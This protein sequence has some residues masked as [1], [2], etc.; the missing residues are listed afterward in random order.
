MFEPMRD[1]F[2]SVRTLLLELGVAEDDITKAAR[3][4]DDLALDSTE[5]VELNVY[6]K[7]EFGFQ[8]PAKFH[9]TNTVGDLVAFV[10]AR[11]SAA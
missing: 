7:R 10:E 6:I 9:K 4:S 5:M 2:E 8:L 1:L 11:A 3:L